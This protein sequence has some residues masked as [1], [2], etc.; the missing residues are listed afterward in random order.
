MNEFENVSRKAPNNLSC[1]SRA[2]FDVLFS[3]LGISGREASG[4]VIVSAVASCGPFVKHRKERTTSFLALD[5]PFLFKSKNDLW[6]RAIRV[7]APTR[8]TSQSRPSA[9]SQLMGGT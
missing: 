8:S 9:I 1:A 3:A 7:G 2:S 4:L 6:Y 5:M